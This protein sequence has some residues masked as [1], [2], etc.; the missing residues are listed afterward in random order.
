MSLRFEWDQQKALTNQVK[1]R[2]SFE[3]PMTVF[4]DPLARIFDD[5]DH[6]ATEPR[7]IIIGLSQKARLLLVCFTERE[8]GVRI[9]S[10]RN[11]TKLERQDYEETQ[12]S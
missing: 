2:V 12:H 3:E 7:E 5:S 11:A 4:S 8:D 6:T 9:F 1:Y 10:A